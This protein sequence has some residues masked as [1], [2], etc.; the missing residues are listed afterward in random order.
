MM[1]TS[2][3]RSRPV[4]GRTIQFKLMLTSTERDLLDKVAKLKGLTASDAVRQWIR[5]AGR[6]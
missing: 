2:K 5:E 6:V 4:S 1:R 3:K